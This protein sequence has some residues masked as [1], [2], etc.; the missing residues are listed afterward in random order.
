MKKFLSLFLLA[1]MLLSMV[2]CGN[3]GAD[4]TAADSTSSSTDT[5][6]AAVDQLVVTD[7]T[8]DG[9]TY[10]ILM[11][12]NI[13]YNELY[14]NDFYFDENSEDHLS[15]ARQKWIMQTE[16]K[17][18]ISIEVVE[19]MKFND[20]TGS[21]QGFQA[22]MESTTAQD[23][24]YDSCMIGTY[25]V[26]NL[27]RN[28]CLTDLNSVDYINLKNS[29]W[30]QVANTDL[31]V[32][33]K[34]YY[35]TGNISTLDNIYTACVLFNKTIVE[36]KNLTSPYE[37]VNNNNWNMDTY[38]TLIKQASDTQGEGITEE[39]K[40]YGLLT[41]NSAML[42]ILAAADERIA[43]VNND[44]E[45]E[46]TLYNEKSESM[47]SKY[48]A[49]SK[50]RAYSVNY[51]TDLTGS[52]DTARKAI[53]DDGRALLYNTLFSTIVHHR[54]SDTNFGIVPY[55]KLDEN[56]E[57]YGHAISAWHTSFFCVPFFIDDEELTGSVSEFMAAKGQ[58]L[59]NPAYY[60][61]T[62]IGQ[63][64]RDDESIEMLDIIFASRVYDLG[65]FYSV[66]GIHNGIAGLAS[67]STT[68]SFQQVYNERA[69]LAQ[70]VIDTINN[71]FKIAE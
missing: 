14:G 11:N 47:Y 43:T 64:V 70:T 40:E 57:N 21:G 59:T 6:E 18:D 13:D 52:W 2:A 30:D 60:D 19:M 50:D 4:T 42:H 9:R 61:D 33:G 49:I 54:D 53:F 67:H 65:I 10:T 15:N 55:P 29:W 46:L 39:Q 26:A 44:G 45:I 22:I 37:Y 36:E 8:Y 48:I 12:G 5:G 32:Q 56:Q 69:Q 28:S 24:E 17:F 27:A 71:D 7:K 62:L 63:Q 34:M 66:G 41:W 23:T 1:V 25:D 38:T 68:S 3:G 58:E 16:Q 20:A 35:T 31:N 51:Q